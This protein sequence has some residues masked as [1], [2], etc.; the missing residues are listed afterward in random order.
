[1][2]LESTNSELVYSSNKSEYKKFLNGQFGF[3]EDLWIKQINSK[4]K[5]IFYLESNLEKR[6]GAS[7]VYA[8]NNYDV[9]WGVNTK[10]EFQNQGWATQMLSL[11]LNKQTQNKRKTLI[12]VDSAS[13][14]LINFYAKLGFKTMGEI[15]IFKNK[16]V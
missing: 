6:C 10:K 11:F 15:V 12:Y 3:F 13:S 8:I 14:K 16:L 9:L 5:D 1:M 4:R 7:I 2:K